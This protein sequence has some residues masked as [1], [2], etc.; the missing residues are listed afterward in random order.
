MGEIMIIPKFRA[1]HKELKK[2][3]P[4]YTIEWIETKYMRICSPQG[5][6]FS[7]NY[8]E[9][10]Q[11]TGLQDKNGKDIYEGDIVRLSFGSYIGS[12]FYIEKIKCSYFLCWK[13]AN[14][15]IHR[16]RL[17]EEFPERDLEVIG[18]IYQQPELLQET[19]C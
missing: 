8:V 11:P 6:V 17:L 1:W 4:V 19:T 18:N 16:D 5:D 10:M 14:T 15:F 13:Q 12:C 2:M 3:Y 7:I 9:I